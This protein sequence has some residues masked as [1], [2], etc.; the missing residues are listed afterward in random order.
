MNLNRPIPFSE[1]FES[2]D[3]RS[4]KR[5]L[6]HPICFGWSD[7]AHPPTMKYLNYLIE[8]RRGNQDI[9]CLFC[10][11]NS[12]RRLGQIIKNLADIDICIDDNPG[13]WR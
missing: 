11:Q 7:A 1:I 6:G 10:L 2:I 9:R 4:Q 3:P 8:N 12:K 5:D 13:A